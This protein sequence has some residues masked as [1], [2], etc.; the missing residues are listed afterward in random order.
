MT[1]YADLV[2]ITAGANKVLL[3][4]LTVKLPILT[5]PFPGQYR[6]CVGSTHT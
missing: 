2:H 1:F 5:G 4:I 6:L 3:W